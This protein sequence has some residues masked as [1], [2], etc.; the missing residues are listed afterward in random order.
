MYQADIRIINGPDNTL[1]EGYVDFKS[2]K[3]MV[4][5]VKKMQSEYNYLTDTE[6]EEYYDAERHYY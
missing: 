4:D 6:S 1:L 3:Q 5:F 2:E